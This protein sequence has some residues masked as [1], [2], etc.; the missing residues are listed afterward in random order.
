VA[1]WDKADVPDWVKLRQVQAVNALKFKNT[2]PTRRPLTE[3]DILNALEKH[4][5]L[6]EARELKTLDVW[7]LRTM[8][9]TTGVCYEMILYEHMGEWICSSVREEKEP[10]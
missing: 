4:F 10:D 5:F 3:E 7:I 6:Y 1:T 2:S 9:L 8:R